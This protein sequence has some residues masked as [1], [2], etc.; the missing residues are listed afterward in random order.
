M[1]ID[2]IGA[3]AILSTIA[4]RY[5]G[6]PAANIHI[7]ELGNQRFTKGALTVLTSYGYRPELREL[8]RILQ[9]LSS[10]PSPTLRTSKEVFE[11]LGFRHTSLDING[12]D[13]AVAVDLSRPLNMSLLGTCDVVTNFGTTEHVGESEYVNSLESDVE[14]ND[15]WSSQYEAFRNLHKL[16]RRDGMII[17]MVPAAGCWPKHGLVE[18]EPRFFQSMAGAAGYE[19][20]NLS[21]HRPAYQWSN[22]EVRFFWALIYDLVER[23]SLTLPEDAVPE[24]IPI[25]PHLDKSKQANVL[26][27]FRAGSSNAFLEKEVEEMDLKAA[28]EEQQL[29]FAKRRSLSEILQAQKRKNVGRP[30]KVKGATKTKKV[31]GTG[32][33][34]EG[35]AG[36]WGLPEHLLPPERQGKGIGATADPQILWRL[37][38]LQAL[39]AN[40]W[41]RLESRSRPGRFY[42]LHTSGKRQMDEGPV[43]GQSEELPPNWHRHAS[44]SRPG[45]FYYVNS[46]TG[47]RQA[48]LPKRSGTKRPNSDGT[49]HV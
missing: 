39:S 40:G 6:R 10:S 45:V 44:R 42:F 27:I 2:R 49:S 19:I 8:L 23:Y 21:L 32:T 5:G 13:G 35:T 30:T 46:V 29:D 24:L 31:Q 4:T 14:L 7:C 3:T 16:V 33:K 28:E 43:D 9:T 47:E 11:S 38:G 18:Y 1:G 17:N 26:S 22:E 34:V 20:I 15:L 37:A 48:E 12:D 41:Q 36:S 25:M